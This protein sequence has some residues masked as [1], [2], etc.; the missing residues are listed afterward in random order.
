MVFL[1]TARW[2]LVQLAPVKQLTNTLNG[3]LKT[4]VN[5][6]VVDP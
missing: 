1:N 5:I 4:A 6:H 2:K 3:E